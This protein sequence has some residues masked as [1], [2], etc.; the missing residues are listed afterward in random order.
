MFST[1]YHSVLKVQSLGDLFQLPYGRFLVTG[2]LDRAL[3]CFGSAGAGLTAEAL[4]NRNGYID[5]VDLALHFHLPQTE[6]QYQV[7]HR[8]HEM[9]RH[10][11]D[12]HDLLDR[13]VAAAGAELSAAVARAALGNATLT[14]MRQITRVSMSDT[15]RAMGRHGLRLWLAGQPWLWVPREDLGLYVEFAE[16]QGLEEQIEMFERAGRL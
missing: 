12:R 10:E 1:V 6:V 9:P 13:Q 16:L 4:R 2:F 8:F 3:W 5:F 14:Y 11:S 7:T 15:S